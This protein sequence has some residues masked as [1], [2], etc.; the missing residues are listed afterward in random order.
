MRW[1]IQFLERRSATMTRA[2]MRRRMGR[3]S[4]ELRV[5]GCRL[6]VSGVGMVM[7]VILVVC[8]CTWWSFV[9]DWPG[10]MWRAFSPLYFISVLYLGLRPRLVCGAPLA[11]WVGAD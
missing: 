8:V 11:L 9:W 5:A 1:M 7:R 3:R 6:S 2:L 4:G 10:V